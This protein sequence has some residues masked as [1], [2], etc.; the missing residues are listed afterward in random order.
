MDRMLRRRGGYVNQGSTERRHA[1]ST[2]TPGS[3]KCD[4]ALNIR[5]RELRS[6]EES[7]RCLVGHE[8]HGRDC[9]MEERYPRRDWRADAVAKADG[10]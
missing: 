9:L 6:H 4:R 1:V 2:L 7:R 5:V 8:H 3:L 10:G